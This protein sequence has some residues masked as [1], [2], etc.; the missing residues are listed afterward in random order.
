VWNWSDDIGWRS[1]VVTGTRE[2]P[3]SEDNYPLVRTIE[4]AHMRAS[5]YIEQDDDWFLT[6]DHVRDYARWLLKVADEI[7]AYDA[8][9][10]PKP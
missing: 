9:E 7:D 4:N 10:E 5:V 3:I 6:T 1:V 2:V 8:I